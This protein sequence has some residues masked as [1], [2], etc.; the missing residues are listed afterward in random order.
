MR[1]QSHVTLPHVAC[2][3]GVPENIHTAGIERLIR[4]VG[5]TVTRVNL[6]LP[7]CWTCGPTVW[8]CEGGPTTTW[9]LRANTQ[10]PYATPAFPGAYCHVSPRIIYPGP[11]ICRC[12]V[13][14]L[15]KA[16]SVLSLC[17][18]KV[19]QSFRASNPCVRGNQHVVQTYLLCYGACKILPSTRIFL[20]P[21]L[22]RGGVL[23]ARLLTSLVRGQRKSNDELLILYYRMQF[24]FFD[25]CNRMCSLGTNKNK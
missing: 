24:F 14:I 6:C 3:S 12:T 11:G 25:E 8:T 15:Q 2:C 13:H 16:G 18:P 19:T 21:C 7:R 4:C 20:G 1:W 17:I 5:S 23:L 9:L 22:P 10:D